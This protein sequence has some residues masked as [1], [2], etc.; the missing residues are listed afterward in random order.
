MFFMSGP[1]RSPSWSTTNVYV[2]KYM[3]FECFGSPSLPEAMYRP[4][5]NLRYYERAQF[6]YII[7][8]FGPKYK[9][10]M[11]TDK[12]QQRRPEPIY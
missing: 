5:L 1:G 2:C 7:S 12:Q 10:K 9:N 3:I 6:Q 4:G 11:G 8:I